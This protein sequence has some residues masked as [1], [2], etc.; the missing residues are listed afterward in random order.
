MS[1]TCT[2]AQVRIIREYAD[3]V[4]IFLDPDTAGETGI[5]GY[6]DKDGEYHPGAVEKLSPYLAVRIAAPHDDDA[7]DLLRD[8]RVNHARK[9]VRDAKPHW[10]LRPSEVSL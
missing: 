9:L 5:W 8:G 10:R 4:V 1:S 7:N 6:T 3:E 2:V